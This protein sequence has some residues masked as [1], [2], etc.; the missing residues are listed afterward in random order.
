M[1]CLIRSRLELLEKL[2][3]KELIDLIGAD[4]YSKVCD[5]LESLYSGMPE[6][7][8]QEIYIKENI[9][10]LLLS[11]SD[12]RELRKPRFWNDL[13]SRLDANEIQR[14]KEAGVDQNYSSDEFVKSCLKFEYEKYNIALTSF[15]KKSDQRKA[16]NKCVAPIVPFKSLKDYQNKIFHKTSELIKIDRNRFIIQMPTGSGKTRTA[17]EIIATYFNLRPE[18]VDVIW[19]AHSV[20]LIE[21]AAECFEEVWSHLG[22]YDVDLRLID[23]N[24]AGL[25]GFEHS[26][27]SFL[28]STFQ[29]L[30]SYKK[31]NEEGFYYLASR[32]SLVVC[33]EAHMVVAP[34]FH[35]LVKMLLNYG[36]KLIGLTATPGRDSS[37][38]EENKKLAE[39]FFDQIVDLPVPDDTSVF[40]HLRNIGV[41]SYATV[42]PIQGSRI[43]LTSSEVKKAKK[44]YSI[45]NQILDKL[46]SEELRNIEIIIKLR[47]LVFK[48]KVSSIILFACSVEHSKFITSICSYIGI[49]SAHIDGD[50]PMELRQSI[51]NKFRR[52]EI[53]LLCN[54]GVLSTGFDAPKTDVVFIARPTNSIVLYSQM[55]GRGLRGPSIG[56]TTHCKV[57]NVVDNLDGLPDPND[58]YDYF[59]DYFTHH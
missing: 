43:T 6:F 16:V 19:L 30:I 7:A 53:R 26:G 8:E 28:V 56:G 31:R 2:P 58:I 38:S 48:E 11:F 23:G 46:G 49:P 18:G 34:T 4:L 55:I 33:D 1:L 20:D 41:M 37:D 39:F 36:A 14:L 45:P 22:R 57:V 54:F 40:D 3:K 51:L 25:E 9:I 44:E 27:P 50:V 12:Q 10:K 52:G 24:R 17:M 29:S 47:N 59:S 32:V 42:E 13:F 5:F 21:Q 35:D 15:N